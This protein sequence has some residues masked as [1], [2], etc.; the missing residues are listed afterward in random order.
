M[1]NKF[2]K[3]PTSKNTKTIYSKNTQN[4]LRL[5]VSGLKEQ[6]FRNSHV[7]MHLQLECTAATACIIRTDLYLTTQFTAFEGVSAM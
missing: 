7:Q 1:L 3:K 5:L 4:Q 2:F 6:T